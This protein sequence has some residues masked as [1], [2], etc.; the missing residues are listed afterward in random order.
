MLTIVDEFTRECLAIDVA[1]KLTSEDVLERLSDLFVCKGVLDN[2]S[3]DSRASS[4]PSASGSGRGRVGVKALFI[5]P[6][7]PWENG[8]V[9]SFN[10][11]LRDELL[12]RETFDTLLE[13]KTLIERWRQ[14]TNRI[15]P[16]SALGYRLPAPKAWQAPCVRF[17]CVS[18]SKRTGLVYWRATTLT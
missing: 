3:S 8:Y 2:I 10:G 18:L 1:K 4:R 13:A 9:E 5:E 7:S 11:N 12:E 17:G 16:H 6:G 14:Y 15:R